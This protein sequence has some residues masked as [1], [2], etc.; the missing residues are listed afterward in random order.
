VAEAVGALAGIRWPAVAVADGSAAR[1]EPGEVA[2]WLWVAPAGNV[3]YAEDAPLD[4]MPGL[5]S[6]RWPPTALAADARHPDPSSADLS[7]CF[8]FIDPPYVGTTGYAHDLPR[9]DVLAIA[10][11]WSNA[12]A[13]VCI[14][15]AE[16]LPLA[17]WHHVEITAERVGQARTFSRQKSEFL[18]MNRPPAVRFGSQAGLFGAA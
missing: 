6:V 16:P 17:G 11:R 8:V 9:A 4:A 2:A 7:D 12:G 10:E 5:A 18:T 15:E 3:R 1:V 14:S 13:L